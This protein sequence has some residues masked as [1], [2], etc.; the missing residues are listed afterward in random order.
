MKR[1]WSRLPLL[2]RLLLAVLLAG[3]FAGGLRLALFFGEA[4]AQAQAQQARTFALAG[5]LLAPLLA[6]AAV[7]GDYGAASELM[8]RLVDTDPAL[9]EVEWVYGRSRMKAAGVPEPA[10]YP[11]WFETLIGLEAQPHA[12][13]VR[14]GD[15]DYGQ[16]LLTIDP[17]GLRNTIWL[18]F[19]RQ[20]LAI[21]A[22]M[23]AAG[24]LLSAVLF[25]SLQA[26]R[27]ILSAMRR[28]RG[29]STVRAPVLGS[30]ETR[31]LAENFN[32]MADEIAANLAALR[33]A[34]AHWQ[35]FAQLHQ[36]TLLAI[37]DAV[38]VCDAEGQITQ[39]NAVAE[40]LT[41]WSRSKATGRAAREVFR[42][43]DP[44]SGLVM[45]DPVAAALHLRAAIGG[46]TGTASLE[47]RDGTLWPV[48]ATAAPI[49]DEAGVLHGCVLV[50]RDRTQQEQIQQRLN[51]QALHDALTGLPNRLLFAD[52]LAQAI[53]RSERQPQLIAVCLFDLDR[54]KPVNDRLGH[55][56]GDEL[57]R[58]V[59]RRAQEV[60][61][62]TDTLAR[63]GGDEFALVLPDLRQVDEAES[64]A[65]RLLERLAE[66]FVL[67]A[68]T[69]EISASLGYTVYPFDPGDPDLLLRHAD[70]AM[71][72]AKHSGRNRLHLY[73]VASD[74]MQEAHRQQLDR[75]RL[76]L[77]QREFEWHYQPKVDMRRGV[78]V[79]FEALARWRH[80]ERG[81]LS[82]L[83]FL[84]YMESGPL[85]IE[86]GVQALE[87]ALAQLEAW[88]AEGFQTRV[89]VNVAPDHFTA[90][91]FVDDVR[92]VLARHP[93]L[94][95]GSLEIE[96]VESAAIDDLA[97]AVAVI[98][99][100]H[101]LGVTVA[102][103]DFG[104]GYASLSY[105]KRLPVDV[106]KIDQSFVR[107][108]LDDQGDLA[109]IEA[110]AALGS[111]FGRRVVAEGVEL[112]EQGVVLMRLGCDLA[113]GYGIAR[114]MP[115]AEV[116][117]WR[118]T[119]RAD[120][121]WAL[122]ADT[123]WE[124]SDFP[125]LVAQYDHLRWIRTVLATLDGAPVRLGHEELVDHHACR[126][127]HWYDTHG[128]RRYG[129]LPAYRALE[130]VHAE[131][132]RVGR[133]LVAA[134]ASGQK[135]TA[136]QL[137]L[138]LLAL[139]DRILELL[140]GLQVEVLQAG[141]PDAALGDGQA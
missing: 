10:V 55:A 1:L 64:I 40:R 71:Y 54:F 24:V 76:A 66:P 28:F 88:A 84:P 82:P 139:K 59:A 6:E 48:E 69:V 80:P 73:D 98:E 79:G 134:A 16:L 124:L 32:R 120:P 75:V 97:R 101:A 36:A 74:Q 126:L 109:L 63:F 37:A 7:T 118:E 111:V 13:P 41:G 87:A 121:A 132:H 77:E 47:S 100:C 125:L 89:A 29:D 12:R 112:A 61:R 130:P 108:L 86:L 90:D 49:R 26:L 136:A 62:D 131:V 93:S 52:R 53:A 122:W 104:T 83:A 78:V 81:L 17:V 106:L 2:A 114:P 11:R 113:Q 140:A 14:L 133:A 8:H 34:R 116:H 117:A 103:D 119:W 68:E 70:Q 18:G 65:K 95:S 85:A 3:G 141:A 42:L 44:A 129:A 56:A 43:V 92:A 19:Q 99:A 102:L 115:A 35:G 135:E 22:A 138:E 23:M 110:V 31:T 127:G 94:P 123:R 30:P 27:A 20:M 58:Q 51:W 25:S 5:E 96:I 45:P 105:L 137:G 21:G 39:M 57:L 38:I 91:R 50:F 33:E 107:D 128:R 4:T 60:L 67:G 15:V 9:A 46:R 72:A